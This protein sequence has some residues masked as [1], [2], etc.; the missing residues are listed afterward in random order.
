MRAGVGERKT[1]E[2]GDENYKE[3]ENSGST[4]IVR[5]SKPR[6]SKLKH[7]ELVMR[8][9]N[10]KDSRSGVERRTGMLG[11]FLVRIFIAVVDKESNDQ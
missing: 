7:S 9:K 10:A 8:L 2:E 3:T 11:G 1:T 4:E 6:G 5:Q